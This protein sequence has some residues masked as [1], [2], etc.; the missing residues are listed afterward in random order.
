MRVIVGVEVILILSV[1]HVLLVAELAV[2]VGL[3]RRDAGQSQSLA[4]GVRSVLPVEFVA[5]LALALQHPTL[6]CCDV[7]N[8]RRLSNQQVL[9][10]VHTCSTTRY[11]IITVNTFYFNR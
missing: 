2:E 6:L 4:L 10:H 11:Y 3:K 8:V 1:L 5:R 9:V 7:Q